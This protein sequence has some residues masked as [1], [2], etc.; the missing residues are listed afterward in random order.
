[1][2]EKEKDAGCDGQQ[3]SGYLVLLRDTMELICSGTAD[4]VADHIGRSPNSVEAIHRRKTYPCGNVMVQRVPVKTYVARYAS[5]GSII[6][7]GSLS[8]ASR[9]LGVAKSSLSSAAKSGRPLKGTDIVVGI[10]ECHNTSVPNSRQL[11]EENAYSAGLSRANALMRLRGFDIE[12]G[13]KAA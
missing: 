4:Y 10:V 2:T 1:M 8:D 6:V 3:R 11:F 5:D 7:A 12:N 13:G 9:H